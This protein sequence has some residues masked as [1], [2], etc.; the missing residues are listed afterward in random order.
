MELIKEKMDNK[1]EKLNDS[2]VIATEMVDDVVNKYTAGLD[3]EL[4]AIHKEVVDVDEPPITL[5][6]KHFVKLANLIYWVSADVESVGVFSSLAKARA[7][8]KYNEAYLEAGNTEDK[9]KKP[10]VAELTAIA[11][12]MTLY[13]STLENI[14]TTAYKT[15][16]N[17][18]QYGEMVCNTLSKLYQRRIKESEQ[19]QSRMGRAILNE[20]IGDAY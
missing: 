14:Y 16:K 11:E 10:T 20:N 9:K 15:I 19:I 12:G 5:I 6:E 7:R 18:I 3:E 8:E 4:I 1:V 13:D 2:V 17:K